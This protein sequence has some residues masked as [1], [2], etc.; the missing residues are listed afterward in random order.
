MIPNQRPEELGIRQSSGFGC[1]AQ[2]TLR[3]TPRAR[4]LALGSPQDRQT[5]RKWR[6]RNRTTVET[7]RVGSEEFVLATYTLSVITAA[8]TQVAANKFKIKTDAKCDLGSSHCYA[9]ITNL[10]FDV[11]L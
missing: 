10:T 2:T 7:N 11:A 4:P 5:L 8:I 1:S 3:D 9:T 6:I